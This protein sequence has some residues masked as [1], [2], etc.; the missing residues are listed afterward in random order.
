MKDVKEIELKSEVNRAGA[1]DIIQLYTEANKPPTISNRYNGLKV[2]GLV[3]DD[4]AC[5]NYRIISPFTYLNM[6]GADCKWVQVCSLEEILS[7]DII[8]AQRQYDKTVANGMIYEAMR[9][10]K[11]VIYEVDDNLSAVLPSS[12]V[13]GIYHNGSAALKMVHEI[14]YKCAGMTVTTYE[15]AGDYSVYNT[16]IEVL[17][18]SIDYAIRD[19]KTRPEDKD[20]EHLVVGWSGGCFTPDTEILTDQGFKF[21]KDLDKTEKV[22]TLNTKTNE[23][24]Y[25]SP[26]EYTIAPYKGKI[27]VVNKNQASYSVTPNHRMYVAKRDDSKPKKELSYEIVTAENLMKDSKRFYLKK[28]A[29]WTGVEVET[30]TLPDGTQLPMDTWL[31]FF[32]FWTAEGWTESNNTKVGICQTKSS[33]ILTEL[34]TDLEAHGVHW[35]KVTDS[36]VSSHKGLYDYLVQ[37]GKSSDKF[38]PREVLNLSSRQLKIFLEY[39]LLGDG[40]SEYSAGSIKPRLR[41]HAVS[42]TLVDNLVELAL[43]IGWSANISN[44]GNSK[45][46]DRDM[47]PKHDIYTV[48]FLG[49]D[50][51]CDYLH[52]TISPKS[53][54]QEVDYEGTVYCVTVPNSVIYTRRNGICAWFGN[55]THL[56]DLQILR[57]VIPEILNKYDY[58]NFGIYGAE[59][60]MKLIVDG[61]ELDPQRVQFIPPRSFSEFPGGLP[62]FDIGLAPTVN[63]RFNAAKSNLK[64]IEYGAWGIPCVASKVPP[65][66]TTIREGINGFTAANSPAEWIDKLSYLIENESEKTKIG[67]KMKSIVENEFDMAKNVHL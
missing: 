43:K 3:A 34:K 27:Q 41:A 63:C 36:I 7:A 11:P 60:M 51:E 10:G 56:E 18:N 16:N 2:I 47:Q 46:G 66:V 44:G 6:H 38:I 35:S 55:S 8:I 17:P 29:V 54:I 4:T 20:T 52:T 5:G 15:L 30:F 32:G 61:W 25:Q 59:Q 37:F 64:V 65:Y 53:D 13:Y 67:Q 23:L 1:E 28:D 31:K 42:K 48:S 21:F 14:I 50:G 39:Y 62:Y 40:S 9:Y 19:W 24:E 22:A 49:N 57:N 12:P 33:K 58:V 26:T 45:I